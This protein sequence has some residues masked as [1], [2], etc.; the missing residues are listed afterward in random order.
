MDFGTRCS[1]IAAET[2]RL[3]LLQ[4]TTDNMDEIDDSVVDAPILSGNVLMVKKL[5]RRYNWDVTERS[6]YN[7]VKSGDVSMCKLILVDRY[8]CVTQTHSPCKFLLIYALLRQ[9]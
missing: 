6:L 7:A 1:R 9:V 5:I 3:D 2:G 4:L 8:I